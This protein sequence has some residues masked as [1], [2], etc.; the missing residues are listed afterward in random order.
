M[1]TPPFHAAPDG[2]QE[3]FGNGFA[4]DMPRLTGA[5]IGSGPGSAFQQSH[6][7]S[8]QVNRQT[9]AGWDLSQTFPILSLW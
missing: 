6:M 2:A 4:I 5:P 3:G 1:G 7:G 9:R 8:E